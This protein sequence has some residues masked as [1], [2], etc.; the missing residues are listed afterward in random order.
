[1]RIPTLVLIVAAMQAQTPATPPATDVFLAP[2]SVAGGKVTIGPAENISR[3]PGYDNQPSFTPDG[4]AILF[5]SDRTRMVTAPIED[6]PPPPPQTDI[7]RYDPSSKRVSQVTDTVQREYSPTVTPDGNGISVI[8]VE[9]DGT[10][11]LWRF[12]MAGKAPVLVLTDIKPV[13]YHAWLDDHTL[14]LFI[15]G[16]RSQ[17]NMLQIADTRT[18]KAQ[19]VADDIG[20]S[21]QRIPG[22][23]VSFVQRE[24]GGAGAPAVFIVKRLTTAKGADGRPFTV[25]PLVRVVEGATAPHLAWTPDGLLLT[26]HGGTLYGWRAGDKSWQAVADLAAL[27]LKNVTRLA[28]SPKG[29]RIAFVAEPQ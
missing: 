18:G 7:Y 11:R 15:L 26:A 17:P 13:G 24:P 6:V 12:T 19:L 16:E 23:G 22:G 29:D 28:V 5:T 8:R 25:D 14:A 2:L 9:G 21:V 10:Q 4:T 1:M 27:G 20:Q 3:S